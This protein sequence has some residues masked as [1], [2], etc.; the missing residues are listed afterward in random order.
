M[1]TVCFDVMLRI[2]AEVSMLNVL[3]TNIRYF[4]VPVEK[5]PRL[6]LKKHKI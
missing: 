3:Q 1:N 5:V 6:P 2:S 4:F